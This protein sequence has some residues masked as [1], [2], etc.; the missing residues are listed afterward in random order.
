MS[1]L[2]LLVVLFVLSAGFGGYR[3]GFVSRASGWA[4]LLL[5]VT[6]ALLIVPVVV[7]L[8][9]IQMVEVQSQ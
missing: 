4:G 9:E 1:L 6:A 3:A 2:D 8:L 5:G 7:R